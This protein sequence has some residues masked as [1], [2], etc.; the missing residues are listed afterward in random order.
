MRCLWK[1]FEIKE[2]SLFNQFTSQFL[3][4]PFFCP[5]LFFSLLSQPLNFSIY[6]FSLSCLPSICL[7]SS[8][9]FTFIFTFISYQEILTKKFHSQDRYK[10]S[11][12]QAVHIPCSPE[13]PSVVPTDIFPYVQRITWDRNIYHHSI[14]KRECEMEIC[15]LGSLSPLYY[16]HYDLGKIM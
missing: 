13:V 1:D 5:F 8:L 15:K 16:L 12:D 7:L 6:F 9:N 14:V 10:N 11:G 2:N 3:I 4:F